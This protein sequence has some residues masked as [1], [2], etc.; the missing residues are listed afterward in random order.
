MSQ[1]SILTEELFAEKGSVKLY[2]RRKRRQGGEPHSVLFLVHGSSVSAQ[3]TFDLAVSGKPDYSMMDWFAD[4]GYD[5]WAMDH[6]GYGKSTVTQGNSDIR[7][8]VDDLA[9]L[10]RLLGE[11][12][13]LTRACVYGLSSGALRAAAF[14]AAYPER[15]ERLALDAFVWTG[16][17]SV[18][19]EKRKGG[20]PFFRSNARRSI[21]KETIERGIIAETSGVFDP[22]VVRA[23]AHQQF[24]L[25]DSVPTGTFLDMTANLPV[26]DPVAISAPTLLMRAEHDEIATLADLADFFVRLASKDKQF[27]F[28]PGVG[29]SSVLGVHRLRVWNCLDAFLR[30]GTGD[31]P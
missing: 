15:I 28:I 10:M 29:H 18:A 4:R 11:R 6:E 9:A 30:A 5:V 3:P 1:A 16:R 22:E 19:L 27:S 14:A 7:C 8:G 2:V 24:A 31:A 20:L 26:V 25:G 13:G 12:T 23:C 21:D 17:D